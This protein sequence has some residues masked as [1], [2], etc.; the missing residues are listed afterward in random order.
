MAG[1]TPV[2]VFAVAIFLGATAAPAGA[3]T[4]VFSPTGSE[5]TFAVPAGVTSVQV[6][7]TGQAGGSFVMGPI[8]S[9]GGRPATVSATVAVA[10][11]STLYVEV[12][13]GA[14]NGGAANRGGG[15]SDVR[16]LPAANPA[17]LSSR[18][19][20]A[21]GGGGAAGGF[22]G[23]PAGHGRLGRVQNFAHARDPTRRAPRAPA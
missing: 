12:G 13:V 5:Q 2:Q 16:T 4:Q 23:A 18:L 1:R 7:A 14:F 21:G 22:P 10:P 17:T 6:T 19:V 11:A 3:Q 9:P 20:V 8:T 15:A